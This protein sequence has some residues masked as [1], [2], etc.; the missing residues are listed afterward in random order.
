MSL[1]VLEQV[2]KRT[3]KKLNE[4]VL[5]LV[6]VLSL[7]EDIDALA[8]KVHSVITKSYKAAC[9]MQKLL[10]KKDNI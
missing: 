8:N 10:L 1:Y 3:R 4:R 6:P 2:Y 9:P 5:P 7:K